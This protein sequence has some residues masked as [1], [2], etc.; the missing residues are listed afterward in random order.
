MKNNDFIVSNHRP[1]SNITFIT[2]NPSLKDY[3]EKLGYNF[4]YINPERMVDRQNIIELSRYIRIFDEYCDRY[5]VCV[6]D[7][8]MRYSLLKLVASMVTFVSPIVVISNSA[9]KVTYK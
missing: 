4:L 7:E 8:M 1:L 2:D 5:I 6:E 9:N 3:A